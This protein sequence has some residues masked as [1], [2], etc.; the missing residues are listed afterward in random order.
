M[1]VAFRTVDVDPAAPVEEWPYEALV[2]VIERGTVGDWVRL[3]RVIEGGCTRSA[4]A[5]APGVI[6]PSWCSV[7]SAESCVSETTLLARLPRS[8]LAS[9]TTASDNSPD[10]VRSERMVSSRVSCEIVMPPCPFR[11]SQI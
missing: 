8:R 5:R 4:R 10:S 6:G 1:T 3:T 11:A 9:R 7:C 2:T